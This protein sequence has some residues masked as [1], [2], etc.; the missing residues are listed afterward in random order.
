MLISESVGSSWVKAEHADG[1]QLYLSWH[2][3]YEK[4]EA[5]GIDTK[6]YHVR[7]IDMYNAFESAN[8]I[9]TWLKNID[10]LDM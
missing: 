5:L 7:R 1:R 10:V 9:D 8:K 4:V 3:T 2:C 6:K